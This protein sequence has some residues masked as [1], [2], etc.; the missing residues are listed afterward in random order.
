MA[1]GYT[2][3]LESMKYD[4][5]K[6]IKE[7]IARGMGV[8]VMFRDDGHK[9]ESEL[10]AALKKEADKESYHTSAELGAA[11]KLKTLRAFDLSDWKAAYKAEFDK[12]K[13]DYEE[14][15]VEYNRKK[16]AHV[17]AAE[18]VNKLLAKAVKQKE[19]D[20]V[21]G[22]LRLA[23]EQLEL[24]IES[25]YQ[26]GCYKDSILRKTL[27]QYRDDSLKCAEQN[28]NYH[29]EEKKKDESREDDRLSGY[30]Q[31]CRFVDGG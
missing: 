25:E 4:V 19:S 24:V 8:C 20:V 28:L 3:Q 12:A 11:K 2:A 6:W 22:T 23:K 21:L 10:R 15:L 9:T 29:T 7:S 18:E 31:L 14:K 26:R 17:K 5:K 30:E 27:E 16:E 13:K 1:T